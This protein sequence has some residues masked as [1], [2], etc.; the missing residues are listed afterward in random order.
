MCLLL[1]SGDLLAIFELKS[2]NNGHEM[3]DKDFAKCVIWSAFTAIS[4]KNHNVNRR[5][6]LDE[7]GRY[8]LSLI[9]NISKLHIKCIVHGD[10][11]PANILW[12]GTTLRIIDFGHA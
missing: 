4:L 5:P 2:G 12:D 6:R 1:A 7:I 9:T 8:S 10:I 3:D 11:K